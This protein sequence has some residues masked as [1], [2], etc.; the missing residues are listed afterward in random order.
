MDISDIKNRDHTRGNL[1]I[2]ALVLVLNIGTLYF[3]SLADG[4]WAIALSF[5]AMCTL[6]TTFSLLHEAVHRSFSRHA[7]INEAAGVVLGAFFPTSFHLQRRFH[8]N[9]H[10]NNRS[11][12]EQFEYHRPKDARWIKSAQWYSILTGIYWFTAVAGVFFYLL[13]PTRFKKASRWRNKSTHFAVQTSSANYLNAALEESQ[14]LIKAELLFALLFQVALCA[15]FGISFGD[16]IL[17]HVPFAIFWSNLQYV[18]HA[19][20]EFD[21]KWGAWNL[22]M[23]RFFSGVLLNYNYHLTHHLYPDVGWADLPEITVDTEE[24]SYFRILTRMWGGTRPAPLEA[25]P[26]REPLSEI[27]KGERHH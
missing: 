20:S 25:G 18:D 12:F 1:S 3:Y 23:N 27:S 6:M 16:W 8:L 10:R 17:Y 2:T 9:H 26:R 4:W 13:I 15:S 7:Y 19:Y 21:S 11:L 24:Q 5:V 22:G 14:T